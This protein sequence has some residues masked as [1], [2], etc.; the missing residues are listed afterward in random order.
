MRT[1][2][3]LDQRAAELSERSRAAS[4]LAAESLRDQWLHAPNETH[5]IESKE[6]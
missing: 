1:Q 4:A 5:V 3:Q 6:N 2:E